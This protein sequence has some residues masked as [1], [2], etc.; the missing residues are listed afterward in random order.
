MADGVNEGIE[1]IGDLDISF[2]E[3]AEQIAGDLG[4]FKDAIEIPDID[5]GEFKDEI[6]DIFG[7]VAEYGKDIGEKLIENVGDLIE[8]AHEWLT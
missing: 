6:G 2:G 1:F 8:N 7:D 4:D 3:I 5:F